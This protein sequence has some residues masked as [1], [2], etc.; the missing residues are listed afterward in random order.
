MNVTYSGDESGIKL[1]EKGLEKKIEPDTTMV[2]KHITNNMKG[3][4]KGSL[5]G[6]TVICR[7]ES[8]VFERL[9]FTCIPIYRERNYL[10]VMISTIGRS[11]QRCSKSCTKIGYSQDTK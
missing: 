1:M 4:L 3:L 11:T 7:V 6:S 5:C 9:S 2:G 10:A 8:W